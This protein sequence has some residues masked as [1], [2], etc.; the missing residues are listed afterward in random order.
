VQLVS[1]HRGD[2]A[3]LE[4]LCL[5]LNIQSGVRWQ[6]AVVKDELK[7]PGEHPPSHNVCCE[8][9]NP[10]KL[11]HLDGLRSAVHS[12]KAWKGLLACHDDRVRQ[13]LASPTHVQQA[14]IHQQSPVPDELTSRDAH[15][16]VQRELGGPCC[17]LQVVIMRVF[18][19]QHTS[20]WQGRVLSQ[21]TKSS[22]ATT[23]IHCVAAYYVA[24]SADQSGLNAW[25]YTSHLPHLLYVRKCCA[26]VP[27]KIRA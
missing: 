15:T 6:K 4:P 18:C 27:V 21:N 16:H 13:Y 24:A 3:H 5:W 7:S 9:L 17:S 19:S 20:I 11:Q 26:V 22:W 10:A 14:V 1:L 12:T 2:S 8:E 23:S 25:A